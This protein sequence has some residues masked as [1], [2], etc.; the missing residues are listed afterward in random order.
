VAAGAEVDA[1]NDFN[2]S[3]LSLAVTGL[4][5]EIVAMLIG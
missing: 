2:E 1:V 3:A 5:V 4:H